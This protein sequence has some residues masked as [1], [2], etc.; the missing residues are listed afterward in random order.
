M[1]NGN[2]AALEI[3]NWL[4]EEPEEEDGSYYYPA[5]S[6]YKYQYDGLNRLKAATY[7]E[8]GTVKNFFNEEYTYDKQGNILNLKRNT[9]G[10]GSNGSF[11]HKLLDDLTLS[12]TGNQLN[13]ATDAY[14][15][16]LS[17]FV[18]PYGVTNNEYAYNKNGAMTKDL[19]RGIASI[20]YNLLNLPETIQFMAGHS[21]TNSYD[22]SGVKRSTTHHTVIYDVE[23]PAPEESEEEEGPV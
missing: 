20:S 3:D 9:I 10:Y 15:S 13:H 5:H 1:Y 12:Y 23:V 22:A 19:N 14:N 6:G 21:T 18:K 4:E 11:V 16:V 7:M 17:G 8:S 2:I